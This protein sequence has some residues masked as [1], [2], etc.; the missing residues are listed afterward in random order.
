MVTATTEHPSVLDP[1]RALLRRGHAVDFLAVDSEGHL[2]PEAV[3]RALRDDTL[4]VSVMAAN[5]EIGV[6]Q[7]IREIA[8]LCRER[9]V[10]FHSDAAQAVGRLELSLERDGI[11]LLSV[12]GHKLYG[13]KGIG[14]LAVRK[15]GK[16][17]P[18]LEPVLQPVPHSPLPAH[19]DD[20]QTEP[21]WPTIHHLL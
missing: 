19:H 12:S 13:P 17:R 6:L 1:C 7:P 2:A 15:H 21:S 14:L 9:G 16:S 4:A 5:N 18:R 8:G 10:V 20:P 3:A 11:D